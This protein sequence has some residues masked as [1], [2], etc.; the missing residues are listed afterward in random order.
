MLVPAAKWLPYEEEYLCTT[1]ADLLRQEGRYDDLV[2]YLAAWV[3]RNPPS[4]GI[5][6][7]YLGA[8]VWSD[9]L[10]QADELVAQ[11][12]RDAEQAVQ[13]HGNQPSPKPLP[14]DVDA[15]LR[16]AVSQ[17]LGQGYN[18][19]TNRIDPQWLNRWPTRRSASPAILGGFRGRPDHGPLHTSSNRTSAAASARRP[20]ACCWTRWASCRSTS[21]SGS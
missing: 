19:N 6:A 21:C 3:K 18:L 4:Q 11:W 12:I 5:Y 16:A 1:Y 2:E 14:A 15:R 9:H 17:A 10:Q 7:Q 8:L 20:C 13:A